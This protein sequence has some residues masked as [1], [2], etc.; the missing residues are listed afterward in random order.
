MGFNQNVTEPALS[1]IPWVIKVLTPNILLYAWA[2]TP[3]TGLP[4]G[5]LAIKVVYIPLVL[6]SKY[7]TVLVVELL[8]CPD[9]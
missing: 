1:V 5:V 8:N 9:K 7:K 2:I 4:A 6:P 3:D